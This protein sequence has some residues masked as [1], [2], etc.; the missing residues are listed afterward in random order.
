MPND[1]E[2]AAER[3]VRGGFY[4]ISGT[5]LATVIM[6]I[7]AILVGRLLGPEMYGDYN[8]AILPPQ[9]LVLF[10]DLG[11]NTGIIKFASSAR[12][13]SEPGKT[14]RIV[15]HAMLFRV[16]A[17]LI[18]SIFALALPG[19]LSTGIINRPNL[20]FYVQI[21]SISILFQI[22]YTTSTSTFVGLDRTELNAFATNVQALAKTTVS[23][24]LVLLGF[25]MAGAVLGYVSGYIVA[26]AVGGLI[27]LILVRSG[28]NET[29]STMRHTFKILTS[30]G[31]PL[32]ISVVLTG[33]LPLLQQVILAFFT[34]SS[35]F[36]NYRAAL[37]FLQ[38]ISVVPVS[39]TTALLPAFSRLDQSAT[40]KIRILFR[41][42]NK[43]T[44][45]LIIPTTVLLLM[46]S[47][48]IVEIVYGSTFD[49]AWLYLSLSCI[50]YF[51][52]A[53]GYLGLASL[54][55]GL[56]ETR[57]TL[58]MTLLNIII[59]VISAPILSAA[60]DVPGVIIS[61][62]ISATISTTYGAIVARRKFKVGFDLGAA[63]K[64]YI[65]S[66][67]SAL[68]PLGLLVLTRLS[69]PLMLAG[70]VL[71]YFIVY[72]TLVPF[73]RIINHAE[74]QTIEHLVQRTRG[75]SSIVEPLVRYEEKILRIRSNHT[76]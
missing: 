14:L 24:A 2:E 18:I 33:F 4:L 11:I 66:A 41:R 22:V 57:T 36:G 34:S 47:R 20:A 31:L 15:R 73:A 52:V 6:A 13:I 44:C 32:Y 53:I 29:G 50:A 63:T 37:N 72:I 30:Y 61:S 42:T 67:L 56:G 74:L 43:Y 5:T 21:A 1:L 40:D 70:G 48:Q 71:I 49:I 16:A 38:L 19:L 58:K 45:M 3:G 9:I 68:P 8:L 59:F 55:N 27:F 64:T 60:Y 35:H 54:F 76:S 25:G 39:L 51:L 46:F 12:Y 75:L 69:A 17:G 10:A 28:K 23:V 62:L 65:V 26:G 7:A